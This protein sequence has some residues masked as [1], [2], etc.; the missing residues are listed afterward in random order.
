M[1]KSIY[2][3]LVGLA[4]FYLHVIFPGIVGFWF[5]LLSAICH[6]PYFSHCHS[7]CYFAGLT[8]QDFLVHAVLRFIGSI[9]V[10]YILEYSAV[11]MIVI[12]ATFFLIL[13][14]LCL[15][16]QYIRPPFGAA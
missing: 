3:V 16:S 9:D 10:R 8:I 6:K 15:K 13:Y 5:D 11:Y 2:H 7:Y 14:Y 1:M 4:C 12:I